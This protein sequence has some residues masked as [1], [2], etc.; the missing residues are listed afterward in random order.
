MWQVLT[1]SVLC[2]ANRGRAG[3]S[4]RFR[5]GAQPQ[6][7]PPRHPELLRAYADALSAPE[8]AGAALDALVY[9]AYGSPWLQALLT[10]LA[11]DRCGVS[12][13]CKTSACYLSMDHA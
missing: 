12:H 7:P 13:Q 8:W 6:P 5:V 1:A 10:A 3:L 9:D 11:P 2:Q 4:A